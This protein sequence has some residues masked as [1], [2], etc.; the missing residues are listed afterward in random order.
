MHHVTKLEIQ[1]NGART[2]QGTEVFFRLT[3]KAD[4]YDF[5]KWQPW[6]SVEPDPL[7]PE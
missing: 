2:Y 3:R 5:A 1:P 4:D 7:Q 6:L